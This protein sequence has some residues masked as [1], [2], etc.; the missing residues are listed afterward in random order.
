MPNCKICKAQNASFSFPRSETEM[1]KWKNILGL[2]VTPSE[3]SRICDKHFSAH[4]VFTTN[5]G[6]RRL[7]K[8][9]LPSMA[10]N[11]AKRSLSEHSYSVISK[12][13]D[14]TA[15]SLLMVMV[16]VLICWGPFLLLFLIC[17]DEVGDGQGVK[18]RKSKFKHVSNGE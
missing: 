14:S 13:T 18:K 16:T 7:K 15:A 11:F 9:A 17:C 5:A 2:S 12:H 10:G 4:D 3:T 8:F 1:K 6:Q